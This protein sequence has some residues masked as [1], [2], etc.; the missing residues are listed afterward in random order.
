[1]KRCGMTKI[2]DKA[3]ERAERGATWLD[4]VY[5]EWVHRIDL[6]TLDLHDSCRCVL[7]QVVD[8]GNVMSY[9]VQGRRFMSGFTLV[10]NLADADWLRDHGFDISSGMYQ[11]EYQGDE[12]DFSDLD[13]AWITVVKRRFNEGVN[14]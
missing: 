13:E 5:P 14:V 8:S 9:H 7:G 2:T 11:G 12:P 4:A 3:L 10:S 6:S 1:M